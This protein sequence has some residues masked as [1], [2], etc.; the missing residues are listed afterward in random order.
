[1][2]LCCNGLGSRPE[3]TMSSFSMAIRRLQ[4]TMRVPMK[5]LGQRGG[6]LGHGSGLFRTCSPTVP[7]V[8]SWMRD[9]GLE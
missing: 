2:M 9:A 8:I 3:K 6:S 1:M 7:G 5:D 4:L